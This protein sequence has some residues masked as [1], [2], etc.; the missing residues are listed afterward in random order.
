MEFSSAQELLRYLNLSRPVISFHWLDSA[1]GSVVRGQRMIQLQERRLVFR[2]SSGNRGA[3]LPGIHL[4]QNLTALHDVAFMHKNLSDGAFEFRL[5]LCAL[6][7]GH[8]CVAVNPHWQRKYYEENQRRG[9][10][11]GH[12]EPS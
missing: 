11:D 9:S 8:R 5:H 2:F 10:A 6:A 7:R 1:F 4:S 3:Q 12:C